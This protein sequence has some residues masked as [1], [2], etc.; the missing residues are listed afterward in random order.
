[1]SDPSG[2]GSG[3]AKRSLF[4]R[5]IR[6]VRPSPVPGY[7]PAPRPFA[8]GLWLIDRRLWLPPG[9]LLPYRM[10][11]VRLADSRLL[12]HSPVKL[13]EATREQVSALGAVAA[14]VAP[15]SFHYLF[16]SEY[17]AAFP[18]ARL[19]LAP[20]LPL[21]IASC[22]PGTVLTDY[23]RTAWSSELEHRVFGPVRNFTEVVFLHRPTSTLILTDLAF[24][25][26][27][28]EGLVQR[29]LWRAGGVPARFGPSRTARLTLLS[30]RTAGAE[31][32][33]ILQWEFDRIVVTHGEP[34]E[35]NGKAV[36][37]EAFAGL[38]RQTEYARR[39]G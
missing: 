14:L 4:D 34:V 28:I 29:A 22:P 37:T 17:E 38:L 8:D 21:R 23:F 9:L 12:L 16:A 5:L 30:D 36:F 10:T 20:D 31:L 2:R 24:N 33:K 13:D 6:P 39:A 27:T 19:F 1:M 32:E 7:A 11:V 25:M 26:V 3:N 15:N 35:R 18:G